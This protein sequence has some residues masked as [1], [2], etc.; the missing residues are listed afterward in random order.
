MKTRPTRLWLSLTL[1]VLT[2][3]LV[4]TEHRA[5][6][7]AWVEHSAFER[8]QSVYFAPGMDGEQRSAFVVALKAAKRRVIGMYGS[9]RGT[10][11]VVATDL[12]SWDRFAPNATGATHYHPTGSTTV[13]IGPNGQNVDVIAHELAHA[14]FV[15]RVGYWRVQLCVPT[16]FDEGLAV[17]LDQRP[18]YT[19]RAFVQRRQAGLRLVPLSQLAARASFFAG[20]KEDVRQHYAH[21]RLAI[22]RWRALRG[23]R[24]TRQFVDALRCD[25]S[26]ARELETIERL[27]P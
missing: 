25:A 4:S 22:E 10:P 15:A 2:L 26:L 17:Q 6:A 14:E 11:T 12:T 13:V 21:A 27:V 23:D 18:L 9:L 1:W 8:E 3:V 7:S 24:A 5:I 20:S 19:E 16:W